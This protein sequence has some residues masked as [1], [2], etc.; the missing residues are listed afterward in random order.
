[1][2]NR[3]IP[4]VNFSLNFKILTVGPSWV[5]RAKKPA[6]E[7][8]ILDGILTLCKKKQKRDKRTNVQMVFHRIATSR[9]QQM[10]RFAGFGTICTISQ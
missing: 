9:V 8:K 2:Q 10:R 1:M 6:K 4:H 7:R 5:L 3:N